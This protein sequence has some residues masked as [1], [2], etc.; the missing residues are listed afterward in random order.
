MSELIEYQKKINSLVDLIKTSAKEINAK[1]WLREY[2]KF[3]LAYEMSR[4]TWSFMTIDQTEAA[5]FFKEPIDDFF[6]KNYIFYI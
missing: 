2:Y 6:H 3:H 5:F 1:R 4:N